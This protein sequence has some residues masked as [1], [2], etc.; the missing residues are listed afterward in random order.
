MVLARLGDQ[1]PQ[2]RPAL[3]P[4]HHRAARR[5]PARR[6]PRRIRWWPPG[7]SAR[8]WSTKKAASIPSSFAWRRCST[9]WTPWEI[10]AR[11]DHP[12]RAVPQPQ[13]RPDFAGGILPALRL[14]NNVART[15]ARRVF[16][17]RTA[18]DRHPALA[19]G[20][21]RGRR[22]GGA[23]RLDRRAGRLGSGAK[24]QPQPA[25][26]TLTGTWNLDTLG[27]SKYLPRPDG[28]YLAQSYAPTQHSAELPSQNGPA[29]KSPP[30]GSNCS[31]TRTSH[32][33]DPADRSKAPEH[34]PNSAPRSTAR[35]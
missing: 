7:S 24:S 4:I 9:A 1:R 6:T 16:P 12:V 20:G 15:A 11:P 3:R 2:P 17:R 13:V 33:T 27:G 25:W 21:N 23:R 30:S 22:A 19:D 14:L 18:E 32:A 8:A 35:T 5:R 29:H 31:T 34:S 10:G 26:E 28:S